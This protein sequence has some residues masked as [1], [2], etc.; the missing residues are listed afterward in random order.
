MIDALTGVA[1]RRHFEVR[2]E[3]E[4]AEARRC[5]HALG[6]ILMDID[7]F[8]EIN[9]Y[10]GH[11][12]GDAVLRQLVDVVTLLGRP[13]DLFARIGG[14]EFAILLPGSDR[15]DCLALADRLRQAVA[16]AQ[17]EVGGLSIPVTASLGVAMLAD[18]DDHI[19]P[20]LSRADH[21]LYGA[22]A[23]GRNRVQG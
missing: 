14:D 18:E 12:T 16:E 2:A 4:I 7:H 17:I 15:E 8:K 6:A 9:D 19:G 5:G 13:S 1:N 22:K 10:Y 20:A 21:A 23:E 3:I 11:A